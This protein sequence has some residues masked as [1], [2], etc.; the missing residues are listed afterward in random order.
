M[1]VTAIVLAAGSG[2]RLGSGVPKPLV[3]INSKPIFIYSLETLCQH[4]AID[5]IIV[6]ASDAFRQELCARIKQ[7]RIRKVTQVVSG[8]RR[9]QDSVLNGL[10]A[11]EQK[12]GLVLIH[13]SARPFIDS[14]TISAVIKEASH[15]GAAIVAVAAKATIKEA[16]VSRG[17]TRVLRTLDR[18]RLWEAQTP[19]VFS[20]ELL[21]QAY[22]K[23]AR[24]SVTDDS[25][26]AE[27]LGAVVSVVPGLYSNIKITTPDD[28]IVAEGFARHLRKMRSI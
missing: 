28:V 10:R 17:K 19:Q 23:F 22:K 13:D 2:S 3:L 14:K 4:P 16:R 7:Y 18:S 9:R 26:L 12:D 5:K 6:V 25:M 20:K 1:F 24:A 27:K 15:S 8:G 21:V 11:V